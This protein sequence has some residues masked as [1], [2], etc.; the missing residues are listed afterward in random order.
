MGRNSEEATKA[1]LIRAVRALRA[2]LAALLVGFLAFLPVLGDLL[3][4]AGFATLSCLS[5]SADFPALV[6]FPALAVFP[7]LAG[8]SALAAFPGLAG[9]FTLCALE[10]AELDGVVLESPEDCPAIG[11]TTINNESRPARQQETSLRMGIENCA[12]LIFSL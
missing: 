7:T 11:R 6:F 2:A 5:D 8:F 1:S 4:P 10:A 12:T 9:F 3:A